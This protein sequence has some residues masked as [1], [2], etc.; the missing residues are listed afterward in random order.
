VAKP[1]ANPQTWE[2]TVVH[3]SGESETVALRISSGNRVSV[4][5]E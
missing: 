2:F 5:A 4:Y 1:D 3:P